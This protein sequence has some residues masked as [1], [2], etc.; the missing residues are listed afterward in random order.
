MIFLIR[1]QVYSLFKRIAPIR[2]CIIIIATD[3]RRNFTEKALTG[4]LNLLH[5]T[6]NYIIIVYSSIVHS[7]CKV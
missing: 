3:I 1:Y 4:H 6:F 2:G 7:V 5:H